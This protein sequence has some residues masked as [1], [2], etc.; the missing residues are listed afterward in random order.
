MDKISRR[1]ARIE[2]R[3]GAMEKMQTWSNNAVHALCKGDEEGI[4]AIEA[5]P[6]P[7]DVN[8]TSPTPPGEE[9]DDGPSGLPNVVDSGY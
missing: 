8:P 3:L 9:V 4:V 2:R 5:P 6:S 1:V 7:V